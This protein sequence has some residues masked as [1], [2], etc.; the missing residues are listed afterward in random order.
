M[1]RAA[2]SWREALADL[3][4]A[5]AAGCGFSLG[6]VALMPMLTATWGQTLLAAAIGVIALFALFYNRALRVV[7][8]LVIAVLL[9]VGAG[10]MRDQLPALGAWWS[11]FGAFMWRYNLGQIPPEMAYELPATISLWAAGSLAGFLLA[12]L[13]GAFYPMAALGAALVAALTATNRAIA[14]LPAAA[15]L[16]AACLAVYPRGYARRL[17]RQGLAI[18]RGRMQ[19]TALIMA[20]MMVVLSVLIVPTNTAGWYS[21]RLRMSL[22]DVTD[23]YLGATGGARART[24]FSLSQTGLSPLGDRLGGPVTPS[25]QLVMVVESERSLLL[26]GAVRDTYTGSSWVNSQTA[27]QYRFG[28]PLFSGR[29]REVFDLDQPDENRTAG[30]LENGFYA[31]ITVRITPKQTRDMTLF[32]AGR[33]SGLAPEDLRRIT[34]YFDLDSQ[35]FS[36]EPVPGGAAYTLNTRVLTVDSGA[37]DSHVLSLEQLAA[38][39]GVGSDRRADARYLQLPEGAADA[40]AGYLEPLLEGLRTPYAKVVAI[41]QFLRENYTY[42]LTPEVPPEDEDF[43]AFFLRSGEGYCTYFASAMTVLARAAGVPARYVEGYQCGAR[44]AGYTVR[45]R[46]AHAWCEVYIDQ[47]GWIPVDA[48]PSAQSAQPDRSDS[49]LPAPTPSH[50]PEPSASPEDTPAAG[51]TVRA[52]GAA[53]LAL[54]LLGVLLALAA[55][56]ALCFA[57]HRWRYRPAR[58]A[59]RHP[60]P[61][62]RADRYFT[63]ILRMLMVYGQ[64]IYEGETLRAYARRMDRWFYNPEGTLVWAAGLMEA[65]RYGGRAPDCDALDRLAAFHG[66]MD[67]QLLRQLGPVKYLL[68][69]LWFPPRIQY[70]PR[71]KGLGER[72]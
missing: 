67:R 37:F 9:G 64:P 4:A 14:A 36:L 5:L 22:D 7:S 40:A 51:D 49:S 58:M 56:V 63:D 34:P 68:R 11:D 26:K 23:A 31:D 27:S 65:L 19:M 42:T 33:P 53:P 44:A 20:G 54:A 30:G 38:A 8:L 62:A 70:I 13:A 16:L 71:P 17:R 43:V 1:R 69:R 12:G 66:Q 57:G 2:T 59:R 21:P 15:L 28:S 39:Y 24:T 3:L 48:T 6:L 35:A 29:Q 55:A 10:L 61:A 18:E 52:A 41:R 45:E 60:D 46:D 50:S 25:D 72:D 47:I 32:T